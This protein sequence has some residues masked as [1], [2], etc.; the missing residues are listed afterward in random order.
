MIDFQP[1]A[2]GDDLT[3][4]CRY[5]AESINVLPV[6]YEDQQFLSAAAGRRRTRDDYLAEFEAFDL[7]QDSSMSCG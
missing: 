7:S 3:Y 2:F 6:Q 4:L 5:R 1:D